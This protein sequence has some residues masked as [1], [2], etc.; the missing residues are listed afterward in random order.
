VHGY[1]Q[2]H[3]TRAL[4]V[5]PEL[6][7]RHEVLVLAGGDAYEAIHRDHPVV[8]IPTLG[9]CYRHNGTQSGFLTLKRNLPA[10]LDLFLRGRGS[11][12]VEDTLRDFGAQVVVA[13]CEPWTHHA[14]ARLG[15]PRIGFDHYSILVYCRPPMRWSDRIPIRRD[16]WVYR[17][18]M[19][20]PERIIVSSFYDA[21]ARRPGVRFVG[22]LLRPEV[23][24]VIRSFEQPFVE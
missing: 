21:P 7:R 12:M 4:A 16:I 17:R 13:D 10:V 8:R 1:G 19:G 22:T 2:G 6:T 14:A 9:Y 11:E 3:A 20:Q 15:I 5:L 24:E 18:L 23:F